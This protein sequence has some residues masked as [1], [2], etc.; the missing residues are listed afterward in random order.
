MIKKE[1][2]KAKMELKLEKMKPKVEKAK[3]IWNKVKVPLTFIAGGL[4]MDRLLKYANEGT[5]RGTIGLRKD[6]AGN[7]Y[8]RTRV[9]TNIGKERTIIAVIHPEDEGHDRFNKMFD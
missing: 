3:V 5:G 9:E 8:I 2:M 6:P 7:I 1:E 4:F